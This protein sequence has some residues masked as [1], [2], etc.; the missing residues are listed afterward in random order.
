M[1]SVMVTLSETIACPHCHKPEPVVKFGHNRSGT[2]RCRCNDCGRTFTPKPNPR[3][4]TPEK[5][6]RIRDALAERLSIDVIARLLHVS[7]TTIY[8]TFKKTHDTEPA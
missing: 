8:T 1:L 7:K 4:V 2:A 3:A 6:Q 5:E